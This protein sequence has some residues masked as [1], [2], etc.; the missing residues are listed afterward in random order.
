MTRFLEIEPQA[1]HYRIMLGQILL[2]QKEWT[3]ALAQYMF[4][5]RDAPFDADAL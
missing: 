5:L 4:V 2:A 1:S 3:R